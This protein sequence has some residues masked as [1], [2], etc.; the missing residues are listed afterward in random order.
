MLPEAMPDMCL[1]SLCPFSAAQVPVSDTSRGAHTSAPATAWAAQ[2]TCACP[3]GRQCQCTLVTHPF[4]G[5]LSDT[6]GVF[7]LSALA[8]PLSSPLAPRV[9]A[10]GREPWLPAASVQAP[11]SNTSFDP[12][13]TTIG[14]PNVLLSAP[15]SNSFGA[16]CEPLDGFPLQPWQ[17]GSA[18][19]DY[20]MAD[21]VP[22]VH[23]GPSNDLFGAYE[24]TEQSQPLWELIGK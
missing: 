24:P 2:P 16:A 21:D 5:P 8:A 20:L 15:A 19:E 11:I 9:S 10:W 18:G 22:L 23:T 4:S 17:R 7:P 1:V 14:T 3:Q 6:S 12:T 13:N